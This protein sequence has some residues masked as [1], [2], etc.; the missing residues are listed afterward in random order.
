MDK[1]GWIC[2]H[3]QI[4]NNWVWENKPFSYGQAWIDMLLLANHEKNRFPL[5][6]EVITVEKGNFV[7]SEL[8][9]MAR[10][11][12]SKTKVRR[13]LKLLENDGMIIKKTD[14]KKTTI[15]IV[16][17]SKFQ[18]LKTDSRPIKDQTKTDSRPIKD[19]NNNDN[20]VN[21]DNNDNNNIIYSSEPDKSAPN[22]S[23]ILIQLND[24]SFYDV[25]LEKISLWENTYPAVDVKQ[26]LKKMAAWCDS[27]PTRRKTRRG[28]ERFI[29]NWLSR[30]QD[31]G[32]TKGKE[33]MIEFE[34]T[35]NTY[36]TDEEWERVKRTIAEARKSNKQRN[37][38]FT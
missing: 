16:N 17:Y 20:N 12:W 4:E 9:L 15:T 33:K 25:P 5:G 32:G 7:T 31:S 35:N 36:N 26:E 38:I 34:G 30:T 14:R 2:L 37:D 29:N 27:N 18:D 1:Q 11:G 13:F 22:P 23:G 8:K 21:N 19:T 24:K 3:R 28:I 6:N 10:W